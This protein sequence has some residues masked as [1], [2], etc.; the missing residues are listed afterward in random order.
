VS[1]IRLETVGFPGEHLPMRGSS[2]TVLHMGTTGYLQS[3]GTGLQF[4]SSL[5][6]ILPVCGA[7]AAVL[8]CAVLC[9]GVQAPS[10]F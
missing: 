7:L 2:R 9:A 4:G 3:V 1:D 5:H 6:G 8:C 10:F